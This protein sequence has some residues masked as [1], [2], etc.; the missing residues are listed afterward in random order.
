MTLYDT[1]RARACV[2]A[3]GTSVCTILRSGIND[4]MWKT[5]VQGTVDPNQCSRTLDGYGFYTMH[6]P[7]RPD[8]SGWWDTAK[9]C[10]DYL[11]PQL[12]KD[13]AKVCGMKIPMIVVPSSKGGS[14][15][16]DG[17]G[18]DNAVIDYT[19]NTDVC[20]YPGHGK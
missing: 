20:A 7:G 4:G 13:P 17:P 15:V 16:S 8:G 3:Q 9:A 5:N 11:F 6:A 19:G 12:E 18:Y 14:V 1:C 2:R 10:E